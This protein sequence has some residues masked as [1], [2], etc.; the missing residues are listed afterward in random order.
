VSGVQLVERM[1]ETRPRLR[2]IVMSGYSLQLSS[3]VLPPGIA[4]LPKPFSLAALSGAIDQ[5]LDEGFTER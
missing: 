3:D 1:R 2:A 5:A 4:F